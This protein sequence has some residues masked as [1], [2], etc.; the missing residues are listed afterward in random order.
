[1]D[2]IT[3]Q[4]KNI[5][6]R[7]T[8]LI[9]PNMPYEQ[10]D[11]FLDWSINKRQRDVPATLSNNY[12]K[13]EQEVTLRQMTEY[14]LEREPI[15]TSWG[16]LFKKHGTVPNPLTKMMAQFMANRDIN[17][18][19]KFSYPK[20]SEEYQNYDMLQLLDKLDNN[21]IYGAMSNNSCVF[22]NINVAA[23]ITGQG[24]SQIA[25]I[26][27]FFESFLSNNVKFGS[28][29]QVLTFIDNT[30]SE[31]ANWHY[32]DREILDRDI[33]VVECFEK[34]VYTCG[35]FRRGEIKWVPSMEELDVLW[36]ILNRLSQKEINRLYYK[37]N[38]FEFCN[39]RSITKALIYILNN[40]KAPF[41]NPNKV[42]EE[43]SVE[44]EVLTDLLREYVFYNYHVIDRI[45]RNLHMIKK[46]TALSDTD[47]AIVS[48]DGWYHFVLDK[49][50]GLKFPITQQAIDEYEYV[51]NDK[52]CVT[53]IETELDYDFYN[54][55][56]VEMKRLIDMVTIIPQDGLRYSIINIMSHI[57]GVLANEHM[58]QYTKNAHSYDENRKCLIISKNE[59]LFKRVLLTNKKKFYA[60]KQEIQEGNMIPDDIDRAL[61]IKGLTIDK[62]TMNDT[63]R[64]RLKRILYEDILNCNYIDQLK[65]VKDLAIFE[66]EI[67][68]SLESGEK[69]FYKPASI[70]SF[71]NYED[72][73]R[74][75]GVKASVVWN[76]VRDPELEAID[77]SERNTVYIVKVDINESNVDRVKESYPEVYERLVS[78]LRDEEIQ[79]FVTEEEAANSSK[80]KKEKGKDG[81][82][83]ALAIPL[84]VQTP[85][86]VS[87]FIDYTSIINDAIGAF[88][89][90][91][92]GIDKMSRSNI[93]Y[94][95]IVKI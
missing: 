55:K 31:E 14:I 60:T 92:I 45:D 84:D 94:T 37:N 3:G 19:K 32:N 87:E 67:F 80:T 12:T 33:D 72:P 5:M 83:T 17:K 25:S 22:Y 43:I 15:C 50:K 93:N 57:C 56:I 8:S 51:T 9:H 62:S 76:K 30:L 46:V 78:V 48:M 21:A 49:V 20:G 73:M 18:A 86:W 23:S 68:Q 16:V 39:N 85:R 71:M 54:D 47:S 69:T 61:D 89:I 41:L 7:M 35:D 64:E 26:I 91:S 2:M 82:I 1:M 40:L 77:L 52:I 38:L 79:K 36:T 13:K 66:K 90:E 65:V 42:P 74:I 63:S 6:G 53:P 28:F 10:M 29:D 81:T 59:F 75:Q 34:I 70:K 4:Y 27:M 24:R 58:E 11:R 88:P 44:M 95:N